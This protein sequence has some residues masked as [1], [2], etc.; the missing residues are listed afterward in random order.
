MEEHIKEKHFADGQLILTGDLAMEVAAGPAHSPKTVQDPSKEL[1]DVNTLSESEW[2]HAVTAV[3]GLAGQLQKE[4]DASAETIVHFTRARPTAAGVS[5][6]TAA[7]LRVRLLALIESAEL[8]DEEA[9]LLAERINDD[10]WGQMTSCEQWRA[11]LS[12]DVCLQRVASEHAA[13][14]KD[15]KLVDAQLK[16]RPTPQG[17]PFER[18]GLYEVI[19]RVA[20]RSSPCLADRLDQGR[21][22]ERGRT[23]L[24]KSRGVEGTLVR[25]SAARWWPQRDHL[26]L[27]CKGDDEGKWLPVFVNGSAKLQVFG[28]GAAEM[29]SIDKL[30]LL[31][32]EA[33][34][35][36]Q[37]LL[38]TNKFQLSR[39]RNFVHCYV[40]SLR[41]LWGT[42]RTMWPSADTVQCHLLDRAAALGDSL[43]LI[44]ST[45][46]EKGFAAVGLHP[47]NALHS[48]LPVPHR[49]QTVWNGGA[50]SGKMCGLVLHVFKHFQQNGWDTM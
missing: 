45:L 36:M 47:L 8:Q 19:E 25:T 21:T 35:S 20:V 33:L 9:L 26:W 13:L 39:L 17:S 16:E 11:L 30:Q 1:L 29:E 31:S 42:D 12:L 3:E 49:Y 4:N 48:T 27:K 46:S 7:A 38:A 32:R 15:L 40:S 23:F 10:A 34:N 28:G 50:L 6:T 14:V 43:E 41:A 44:D 22:P 2:L 24:P 37:A 18:V 5:S